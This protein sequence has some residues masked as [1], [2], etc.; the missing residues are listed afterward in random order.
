MVSQQMITTVMFNQTSH[1]C[2]QLAAYILFIGF[3]WQFQ[4]WWEERAIIED[5]NNIFKDESDL[6]D[7]TSS[8]K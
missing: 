4:K 8:Q 6:Q 2:N 3:I 1:G 5:K 7:R